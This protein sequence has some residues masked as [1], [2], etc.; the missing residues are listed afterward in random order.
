MKKPQKSIYTISNND[1]LVISFSNY[2]ARITSVK[3]QKQEIAR[4]GF[5]SG[6]CANRIAGATFELNNKTYYLD[7][8][9][10]DNHLHGGS[11]GFAKRF[12]SVKEKTDHSISFYLHSKDKDMGYPGNLDITVTY[13]LFSNELSVE[14]H[15]TC[16][17]DTILNPINHLYF[18]NPR[19]L[20]INADYFTE[21]GANRI[22]TG[23]VLSTLD[24]PYDFSKEKSLERKLSYD[25]NYVLKDTG[26]RKVAY[27]KSDLY[28]VEVFTDRPGLQLYQTN[29]HVCLEAQMYP[30]A[31]HHQNFPS[32]ILKKDAAFYSKT[33]Y[34]FKFNK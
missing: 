23:R 26:Y 28:S 30:D 3:Y 33:A 7:K 14:Y 34:H 27:L 12:W 5:I 17:Q 18:K 16:D 20:V 6:R 22:P 8:N 13:T 29:K 11:K 1:G 21:K 31:I 2:G 32:P 15:A 25:I 10:G 4:N 19:T 24:T 9:E